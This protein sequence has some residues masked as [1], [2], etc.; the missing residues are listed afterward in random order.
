MKSTGWIFVVVGAALLAGLFVLF[1]PDGSPEPAATATAT[2]APP[3]PAATAVPIGPRLFQVELK[4]NR[5]ASG[6]TV[7]KVSQGDE[8][9]LRVTADKADELHLHGYDLQLALKPGV[10]AELRFV[11][12][13]SGRFEY[14]L[15]HAHAEVG[16]LEVQPK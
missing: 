1:K 12:S 9:L 15:H 13:R 4:D 11:A 6:P 10:P 14:E 8:V 7:L 2:P 5:I 3:P 16:A